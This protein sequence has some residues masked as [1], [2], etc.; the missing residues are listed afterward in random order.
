[1]RALAIVG[2]VLIAIG[3]YALATGSVLTGRR[4]VVDVG[5]L[6]ISSEQHRSVEPWMAGIALAIGGALVVVGVT[7]KK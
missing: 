7:R 4:D 2:I 5:G 3:S 1:M 6:R